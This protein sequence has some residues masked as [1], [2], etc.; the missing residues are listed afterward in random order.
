M[1]AARGVSGTADALCDMLTSVTDESDPTTLPVFS[2]PRHVPALVQ[3]SG[4]LFHLKLLLVLEARAG[5]EPAV[6]HDGGWVE[7]A[8][9]IPMS[10][11]AFLDDVSTRLCHISGLGPSRVIHW[12]RGQMSAEAVPPH[13]GTLTSSVTQSLQ[14][15]PQH[16]LKKI[17]H[18]I[19]Q[20]EHDSGTCHVVCTAGA[21]PQWVA[22][23]AT[24][25]LPSSSSAHTLSLKHSGG[26]EDCSEP[27]NIRRID[28]PRLEAGQ[29]VVYPLERGFPAR[30]RFCGDDD[31]IAALEI[32]LFG[33]VMQ[34]QF[35]QCSLSHNQTKLLHDKLGLEEGVS[36]VDAQ[37]M[38][39]YVI[40]V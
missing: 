30:F 24:C 29:V 19:E 37:E 38:T 3:L 26:L 35:E 5:C 14:C 10:L 7:R 31:V 17:L 23:K 15:P 20:R 6:S 22:I 13:V 2:A 36:L 8:K 9:R 18:H 28:L 34:L 11:S 32:S 40:E 1:L 4:F 21:Q 27:S 16:A 39:S 25:S 33:R 12:C